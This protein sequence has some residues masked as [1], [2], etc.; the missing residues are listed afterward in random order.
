LIKTSA[1]IHTGH[2]HEN[3]I[4]LSGSES[5]NITQMLQAQ[6]ENEPG[7]HSFPWFWG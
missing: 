6:M 1:R 5:I 7:L 4:R 2:F 3:W